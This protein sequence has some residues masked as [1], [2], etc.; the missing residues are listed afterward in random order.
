MSQTIIDREVYRAARETAVLTDRSDLGVLHIKGKTRLDLVNRMSTQKVDSL[1]SGEGAATVLTSDIGRI[2]DRLHLYATSDALYALTS[3]NNGEKIQ[4]YLQR[5]VFFNDDF[6]MQN[7]SQ[8]TFVFGVYGPQAGPY[9]AAAG[10]PEATFPLHHWRPATINGA[11]LYLHRTDPIHGDGYFVMGEGKDQEMAWSH[12]LAAG[13]MVA[14][15]AVYELLRIEAG[16]PRLEQ[17]M[18]LDYIPLEANMWADVSFNKGCYTGQEIIARME[19][20]GRLAKRLV[21]LR[22]EAPIASN[23]EIMAEGKKAGTVTSVATGPEGHAAL[24]YVKT[25]V[26]EAGSPLTVGGARLSVVT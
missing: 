19:S 21:R 15:A 3:E 18:T 10:L 8:E 5:F 13:L 22:S 20:R 26:L 24:G 23:A 12:L 9:L 4:Q 6:H 7:I 14:D 25:A 16:H 2:I 17:E 11:D 1:Q